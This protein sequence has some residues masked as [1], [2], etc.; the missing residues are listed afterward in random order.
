MQSFEKR[1]IHNHV[2][3]VIQF[4]SRQMKNDKGPTTENHRR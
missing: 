2:K 1:K 3:K 4:Y